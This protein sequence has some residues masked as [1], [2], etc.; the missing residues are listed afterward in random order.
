MKTKLERL[1]TKAIKLAEEGKEEIVLKVSELKT[2]L[3]RV[4]QGGYSL[5]GSKDGLATFGGLAIYVEK[6]KPKEEEEDV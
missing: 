4:K 2:I 1:E 6:D 5:Y 3:Q